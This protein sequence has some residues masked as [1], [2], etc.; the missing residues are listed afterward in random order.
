MERKYKVFITGVGGFLG[1]HLAVRMN[2]L[3]YEVAGNDTFVGGEEDN[4]PD[5]VD[6]SLVDC[7]D[8]KGMEKA[9]EGCD[10]LYH[11]AATAHEG[12]SVFSPS[13]ITRNIFEASVTSF[14]AAISAGVK[15]I[16]FC[17]SMARY[18]NQAAPFTEDMQPQPIDRDWET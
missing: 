13:F 9:M 18:G 16:V 11:C 5:F 15:R 7:C 17:T 2:E 1:H 14:S 8:F 6:F 10:L 12:L 3:G 4:V